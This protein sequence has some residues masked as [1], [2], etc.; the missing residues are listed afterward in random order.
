LGAVCALLVEYGL[1]V[2]PCL[3]SLSF[4]FLEY[5]NGENGAFIANI[6]LGSFLPILIFVFRAFDQDKA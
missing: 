3:Y 4:F 5:G 2:I 6:V 1:T